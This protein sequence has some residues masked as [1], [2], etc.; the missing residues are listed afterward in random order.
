MA[1]IKKLLDFYT[2]SKL[3]NKND[4]LDQYESLYQE[5][6]FASEWFVRRYAIWS[7]H[8]NFY[9]KPAWFWEKLTSKFN[10]S[11]QSEYLNILNNLFRQQDRLDF[12][13]LD[14][15]KLYN[16]ISILSCCKIDINQLKSLLDMMIRKLCIEKQRETLRVLYSKF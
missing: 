6:W 8:D 7:K 15:E 10:P 12:D 4:R 9:R 13:A 14:F 5:N 3:E 2:L 11:L 1:K 16:F